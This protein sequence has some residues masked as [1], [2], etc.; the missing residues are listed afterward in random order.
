M[1]KSTFIITKMDCPSE[2]Q[3]I[4]MKLE[5]LS[6]VKHLEFDIPARKLE[7]F[8]QDEVLPIQNAISEL[9]LSDQLQGT[10]E[11]EMPI[12]EDETKH[13]KILWWVL[14]INF[15]F[16]VAE[17]TT[18]WISS[19]MGL[20]ADSLDMLA[21]SI[22]YALSLFA[23]GAAISR[24]K[25]VAKISGYFQMGLA[26]LGFSEVLRRFF[27]QSETPLFQWMIIVSL[28]ALAGNLVSLWLINKAKSKE[29]HM[30]ASAIFTSNDI[31]VNGGVI[32]AGV[33]VYWLES[34][35]PDLFVGGV[36]FGFVM[37]GAIRIL[38]LAK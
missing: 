4:R 3:M 20:I 38:K 1:N 12:A 15:G 28:L 16:F 17:M 37:R 30:Q 34:K 11:A 23:V 25:K 21:D 29:A 26:L 18:G 27:T 13:K 32:L 9:N 19:S 24:K 8:H 22:V 7:V 6:Q 35:W 14:G 2:E 31:I 10:S 5:P 36:V 33:L